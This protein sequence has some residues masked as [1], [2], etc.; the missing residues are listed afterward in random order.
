MS[1]ELGW[2][3]LFAAW[4][5]FRDPILAGIIAG[6]SLGMVGVFVVLRRL[7]FVSAALTQAAGLGVA[8]AFFSGIHLGL[9]LPPL[10]GALLGTLG[11]AVFV[12]LDPRR[13][14]MSR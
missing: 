5:L 13:L 11:A 8:V 7:V 3:D 10:A 6:A 12:A 4:T 1:T 2:A 9:D 14:R